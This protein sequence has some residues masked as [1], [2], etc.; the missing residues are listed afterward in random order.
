MHWK[1]FRT[2]V[3]DGAGEIEKN[4]ARVS[5]GLN[6]GLHGRAQRYLDAEVSSISRGRDLLHDN[7]AA[8]TLRR[9]TRPQEHCDPTIFLRHFHLSLTLAGTRLPIGIGTSP[10]LLFLSSNGRADF[11]PAALTRSVTLVAIDAV[12]DVSR[13]I[14]VVKIVRVVS[15]VTAR[16]LED[17]VVVRVRV[18]RRTDAVGIA[19][20]GREL[21]VLRVIECRPRPRP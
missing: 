8:A 21:R 17:R 14:L 16:A 9:R 7:R 4:A 13:N 11:L 20:T 5:R 6:Y 18:A 19:V 15:A 10:P 3:A 2:S 1:T 12:V